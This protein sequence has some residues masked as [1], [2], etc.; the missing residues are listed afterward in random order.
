MAR[1]KRKTDAKGPDIGIVMTVSLFLI[2]LTFFILLNSIAVLDENKT[3]LAIGSLIGAFGGLPGGLSPLATGDSILPPTAPIVDAELTV[4]ELLAYMHKDKPIYAGRIKTAKIKGGELI[5]INA[6]DLFA[7][8]RSGINPSI[9]LLL[10]KLGSLISQGDYPLEIIGHTDDSAPQE[11]GYTSNWE[12]S[13]LM[14][15]R[16][17]AYFISEHKI[18]PERISAY[19]YGATRPVASNESVHSRVK[20]RRVEIVLRHRAPAYVK[21]IFNKKSS[22]YFTYKKFDFKIF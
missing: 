5:S 9:A 1:K 3:R 4:E 14:A 6:N 7:E 18:A 15:L 22:G 16:V 8:D 17:L 13:S 20:N 21:R 11:K 10:N 19:G 12:L 2:L